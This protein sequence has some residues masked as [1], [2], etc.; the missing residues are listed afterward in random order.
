MHATNRLQ[1]E[2][3]MIDVNLPVVLQ[4]SHHV[5]RKNRTCG[6]TEHSAVLKT[7]LGVY[8]FEI[9]HLQRNCAVN[10]QAKKCAHPCRLVFSQHDN[11]REWMPSITTA[12]VSESE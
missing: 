2:K 10:T 11:L 4:H 5:E 7:Y 12:A 6:R 1:R 3:K 9:D 8:L